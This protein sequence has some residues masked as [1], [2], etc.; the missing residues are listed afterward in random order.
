MYLE[1][2]EGG[3]ALRGEVTIAEKTLRIIIIAPVIANTTATTATIATIAVIAITITTATTATPATTAT[4]ATTTRLTCSCRCGGGQM[5]GNLRSNMLAALASNSNIRS[6]QLR[7]LASA[8]QDSPRSNEEAADVGDK[9]RKGAA[10]SSVGGGLGH[11]A[12]ITGGKAVVAFLSCH[13]LTSAQTISP[14]T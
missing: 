10:W 6:V 13:I 9:Q 2:I 14:R 12:V 3:A 8:S 7:R 1:R 11:V 5:Q 4:T